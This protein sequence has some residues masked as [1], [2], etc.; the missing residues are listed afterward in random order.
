VRKQQQSRGN[1]Q[2]GNRGNNTTNTN[3][4]LFTGT[5]SSGIDL[6]YILRTSTGLTGALGASFATPANPS[7]VPIHPVTIG[8]RCASMALA[9]QQWRLNRLLVKYTPANY[10]GA[11]TIAGVPTGNAYPAVSS[12]GTWNTDLVGGFTWDSSTGAMSFPEVVEA[13]G[14]VFNPA[15]PM[16]WTT[17]NSKWYYID[18]RVDDTSSEI[19]F[20]SPCQFNAVSRANGPVTDVIYGELMFEWDISFRYPQEADPPQVSLEAVPLALFRTTIAKFRETRTLLHDDEKEERKVRTSESP[21]IV[22]SQD[23]FGKNEK[24]RQLYATYLGKPESKPSGHNKK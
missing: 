9:F 20:I 22:E 3:G 24:E 23:V 7:F 15:R 16:S 12:V 8:N 6:P 19:R 21:I 10:Q 13:G 18:A 4:K 11:A 2:R 1:A 14:K 17:Q 5:R